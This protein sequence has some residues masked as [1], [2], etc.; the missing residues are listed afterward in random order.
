MLLPVIS[1]KSYNRDA[2]MSGR[3]SEIFNDQIHESVSWIYD[4][5]RLFVQYTKL[6]LHSNDSTDLG[7][8]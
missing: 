4:L 5:D 7:S 6:D 1:K 8:A 3:G 2:Q